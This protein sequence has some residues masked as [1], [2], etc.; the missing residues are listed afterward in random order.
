MLD[1]LRNM[2]ERLKSHNELGTKGFTITYKPF[3][4]IYSEIFQ[5][6]LK[7]MKR[8]KYFKSV[9]EQNSLNPHNTNQDFSN[10]F[11]L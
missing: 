3:R 6:K 5:T 10:V 2:E 11:F 8:V 1:I 4:L 7:G 9:L